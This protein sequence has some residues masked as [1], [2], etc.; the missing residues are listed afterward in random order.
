MAPFG[1]KAGEGD[2]MECDSFDA[3]LTTVGFTGTGGSVLG[4]N[5][6][7]GEGEGEGVKSIL[8]GDG[9]GDD[10]GDKNGDSDG[11]FGEG[12]EN[13]KF[14]AEEGNGDGDARPRCGS[15]EGL[16]DRGSLSP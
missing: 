9:D 2:K 16:C 14:E 3:G 8:E 5:K 13:A 15:E 12:D 7:E 6:D 1:A 10:T 4:D 11:E